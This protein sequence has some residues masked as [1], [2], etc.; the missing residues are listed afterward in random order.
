MK[1]SVYRKG[2]FEEA[3]KNV[4]ENN[5]LN[6]YAVTDTGDIVVASSDGG[7]KFAS[8]KQ[9]LSGEYKPL[10]NADLLRLRAESYAGN[11]T[12]T[13]IVSNGIGMEKIV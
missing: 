10:T 2:A 5:G 3:Y 11:D 4:K 6:E 13:Q 8:I 12:L 7:I 9:V 1:D